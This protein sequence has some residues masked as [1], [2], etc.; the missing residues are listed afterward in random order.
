MTRGTETSCS[1]YRTCTT[2]SG[3]GTGVIVII[4][5]NVTVH[6]DWGPTVSFT[7]RS[8]VKTRSPR[9]ARRRHLVV[10]ALF[11][12]RNTNAVRLFHLT[13]SIPPIIA[14]DLCSHARMIARDSQTSQALIPSSELLPKCRFSPST[15]VRTRHCV[16]CKSDG[17]KGMFTLMTKNTSGLVIHVC[18]HVERST[19]RCRRDLPWLKLPPDLNQSTCSKSMTLASLPPK[20]MSRDVI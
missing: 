18:M 6:P 14:I 3:T 20:P 12:D 16:I 19:P 8:D 2:Q 5:P 10:L 11:V 7:R 9:F 15:L 4:T 13:P 1:F 17:Q